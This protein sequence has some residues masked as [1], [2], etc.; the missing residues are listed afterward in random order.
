MLNSMQ[1][2]QLS[3]ALT[4]TFL[5]QIPQSSPQAGALMMQNQTA[6]G[7]IQSELYKKAMKKQKKSSSLPGIF[8]IGEDVINGNWS[9]AGEKAIGQAATAANMFAGGGGGFGSRMANLSLPLGEPIGDH[10][11]SSAP[12][13]DMFGQP[14]DPFANRHGEL[15]GGGWR[16]STPASGDVA[17]AAPVDAGGEKS[18]GGG[19]DIGAIAAAAGGAAL[20]K[21]AANRGESNMAQQS[22]VDMALKDVAD[23]RQ[24]MMITQWAQAG[25]QEFQA[26]QP[27]QRITAVSG[28]LNAGIPLTKAQVRGIP[29]SE[30]KM[31]QKQY[32]PDLFPMTGLDKLTS[33]IDA[34]EE[35]SGPG[36][37]VRPYNGLEMY[38]P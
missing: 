25:P 12:T 34:Y 23:P 10:V 17:T 19:M 20:L 16:C 2:Y 36:R 3:T 28:L 11:P 5:S 15:L 13:Q 9:G 33:F 18:A 8:G 4:P 35:S 14:V 37:I 29:A 24:R 30:R 27:A 6:A 38:I 7:G 21:G 22:A 32:G 1:A 31:Y 26:M